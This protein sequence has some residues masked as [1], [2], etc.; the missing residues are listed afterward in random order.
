M[1]CGNRQR[2]HIK[3]G[4]VAM[5]LMYRLFDRFRFEE[6][7]FICTIYI[8]FYTCF[9]ISIFCKNNTENL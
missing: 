5:L 4:C 2:K 3:K 7:Y 9:F 8:E 1:L 6:N